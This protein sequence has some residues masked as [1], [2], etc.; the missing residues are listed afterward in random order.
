MATPRTKPPALD[1]STTEPGD[2]AIIK[3]CILYKSALGGS[4]SAHSITALWLS[5]DF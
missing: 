1:D 4:Q 2:N 5:A 3:I